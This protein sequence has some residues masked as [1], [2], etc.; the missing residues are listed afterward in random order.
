MIKYDPFFE[1]LKKKNITWYQ[2]RKKYNF[3]ESIKT[4]L[5]NNR[6]MNIATLEKLREAL[7]CGLDEIAYFDK[8]ET[9]LEYEKRVSALF[10]GRF[11][12]SLRTFIISY[13]KSKRFTLFAASQS[14]YGGINNVS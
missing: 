1:T 10:R 12:F 6:T 2:L 11:P 9:R 3:S 4:N 14:T 5:N 13:S 7:D 8:D